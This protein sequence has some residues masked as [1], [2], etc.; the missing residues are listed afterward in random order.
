MLSFQRFPGSFL[1]ERL[2]TGNHVTNVREQAERWAKRKADFAGGTP[3]VNC[4]EW[5]TDLVGI[6]SK[7]FSED[8]DSWIDFVL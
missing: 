5:N 8:L 7:N 2:G 6:G 4:Y 1:S 3:V